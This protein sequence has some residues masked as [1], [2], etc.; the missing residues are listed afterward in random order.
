[1][2][3][4]EGDVPGDRT[5]WIVGIRRIAES[6]NSH[7]RPTSSFFDAVE[8]RRVPEYTPR[9]KRESGYEHAMTTQDPTVV[10]S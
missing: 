5:A 8:D 6:G 9:D 2:W 10:G 3:T 7:Y 4:S 1:M